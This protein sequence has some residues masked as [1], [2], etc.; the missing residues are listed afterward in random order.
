MKQVCVDRI[1][2]I[3]YGMSEGKDTFLSQ[4]FQPAAARNESNGGILVEV[5]LL[6]ENLIRQIVFM[7]TVK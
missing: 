2:D 1:G 5:L 3:G 4:S 7:S 6:D